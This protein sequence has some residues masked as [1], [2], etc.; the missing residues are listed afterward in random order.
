MSFYEMVFIFPDTTSS[1]Q[2]GDNDLDDKDSE[3]E[4]D[5]ET[6]TA[7]EADVTHPTVAPR[8]V[9]IRIL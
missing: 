7:L 4:D 9:L 1:L 3:D 2:D 5:N 8:L 6:F